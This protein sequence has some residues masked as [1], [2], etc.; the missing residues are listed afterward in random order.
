MDVRRHVGPRAV[1]ATVAVG[2]L[3]LLAGCGG[4]PADRVAPAPSAPPARTAEPEPPDATLPT[5]VGRSLPAAE[6]AAQS[7]GFF[8]LTS[9]DALGRQRDQVRDR[10]W[11][12][13][14]QDPAPGPVPGSTLVSLGAVRPGEVCPATDLG[15][16]TAADA[17]DAAAAPSDA[18]AMPDVVG[19]S[20][21]Q[22]TRALGAAAVTLRDATGAGRGVGGDVDAARGWQVC[23]QEPV[24]GATRG[25]PVTLAV[26]PL[27]EDC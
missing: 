10:D 15:V 6:E 13:C 3:V 1:G 9:H 27:A 24:A 16:D 19:L 18:A 8:A 5:L 12:V 17:A 23:A 21:G 25:G 26:V 2:V 11:T 22:A 14:F 20:V 7:A 4:S